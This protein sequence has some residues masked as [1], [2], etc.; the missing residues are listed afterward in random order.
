MFIRS[1]DNKFNSNSVPERGIRA[2]LKKDGYDLCA[3]GKGGGVQGGF[4]VLWKAIIMWLKLEVQY[5]IKHI[6]F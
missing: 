5:A 4:T 6:L 2:G 3:S 1:Y